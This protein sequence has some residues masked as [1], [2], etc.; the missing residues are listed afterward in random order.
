M[1]RIPGPADTDLAFWDFIG[2]R[3]LRLGEIMTLPLPF[4]IGFWWQC[5]FCFRLAGLQVERE[6]IDLDIA[7]SAA[8]I[9][10][11]RPI[12]VRNA[13]KCSKK[14]FNFKLNQYRNF[15]KFDVSAMACGLPKTI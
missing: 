6:C 1:A 8:T 4:R 15:G 10:A 14:L 5:S 3:R 13:E 9:S 2:N 11:P 12:D 7:L